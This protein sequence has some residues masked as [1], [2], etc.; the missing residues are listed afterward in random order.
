[1]IK[2]TIEYTDYNGETRK[3]DFYFNISKGE[4][5]E[6]ETSVEG[7]FSAL[8]TRIVNEKDTPEIM[9]IFKRIILKAYGKKSD[10]GRRF[11]KSEELSNEF[12]QT[13]AYSELLMSLMSSPDE[14]AAFINGLLPQ[15][16][17]DKYKDIDPQKLPEDVR[18]LVESQN[19]LKSSSKVH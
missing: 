8:L 2:K 15:D 5:I 12:T 6:M 19:Q 16:L 10:D 4:I 3:E 9:K 14:A 17:M 11:I 13:E 7:G 1:M 18:G